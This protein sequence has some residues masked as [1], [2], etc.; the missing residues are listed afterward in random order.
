LLDFVLKNA[1]YVWICRISVSV[2]KG[3]AKKC[4]H[5]LGKKKGA[6]KRW[7]CLTVLEK[8]LKSKH[9]KG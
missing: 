6:V 1:E 5:S 7:K 9:T 4:L 3:T 2:L 8:L